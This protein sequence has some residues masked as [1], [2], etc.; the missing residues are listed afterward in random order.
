M[1]M[2]SS[3]IMMPAL[4]R[5]V[6]EALSP[7]W[8]AAHRRLVPAQ[9]LGIQR[10]TSPLKV[11]FDMGFR[12]FHNAGTRCGRKRRV[13]RAL[14]GCLSASPPTTALPPACPWLG[15]SRSSRPGRPRYS[16]HLEEPRPATVGAGAPERR[17]GQVRF[18]TGSSPGDSGPFGEPL[19]SLASV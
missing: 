13:P 5:V 1:F 18:T 2:L 14:C 15:T 4:G 17:D 19:M 3:R 6:G 8:A 12:R 10:V 9:L 11:V 16:S 7:H